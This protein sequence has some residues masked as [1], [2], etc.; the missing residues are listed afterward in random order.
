[1]LF[2]IIKAL[3][4][5]VPQALANS[6]KIPAC[7]QSTAENTVCSVVDHYDHLSPPTFP[8]EI[9][10]DIGFRGIHDIDEKK[11]TVTFLADLGMS[12]KE[13]RLSITNTSTDNKG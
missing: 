10:P 11:H 13:P 3:L 6:K 9:I 12:W 2:P 1:M 8:T 4:L 7:G 5:I